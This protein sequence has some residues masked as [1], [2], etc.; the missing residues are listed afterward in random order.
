MSINMPQKSEGIALRRSGDLH[1]ACIRLVLGLL[2]CLLSQNVSAHPIQVPDSVSLTDPRFFKRPEFGARFLASQQ[3]CEADPVAGLAQYQA[4]WKESTQFADPAAQGIIGTEIAAVLLRQ[5][6]VSEAFDWINQV[7]ALD[8][9]IDPLSPI[10]QRIH[11]NIAGTYTDFEAHNLAL[12]HYKLALAIDEAR[13]QAPTPRRFRHC[14]ATAICFQQADRLDSAF[15]YYQRCINIATE[16]HE[17]IWEA[18]ARNNLGMALLHVGNLDSALKLYQTALA[19]LDPTDQT[20]QGFAVS[21]RDNIGDG[22]L[23]S[24]RAAEALPYFQVNFDDFAL[25]PNQGVHLQ[26]G[27]RL[28]HTFVAMNRLSEAEQMLATMKAFAA[29][30]A[31]SILL[32]YRLDLLETSILVAQNTHNWQVASQFQQELIQLRDS[33]QGKAFQTKV[34]TLE[35]MLIDKTTHF[36]TEIYLS[37]RVASEA[38]AKASFQILLVASAAITAILILAI[39]LINLRRRA[40]QENARHAQESYARALAEL[41][42]KNER[43]QNAQLNQALEMKRRDITDYA[44]VYSQRRNAFE[45]ILDNLKQIRRQ[46]NPEKAVQDLIMTLKGKIEGEGK[47]SLEAE[48]IEKVNHAFFDDL[49]QKFPGLSSSELELCGM[50]RLGHSSKDIALRKNIAPA[51]VRIAKTRLKKKMGLG[52]ETDLRDFLNSI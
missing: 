7:L 40:I 13:E 6:R 45:E 15:H 33:L 49:K 42:L 36:N 52:P 19:M 50:L 4:L 11:R 25:R 14:S 3:L 8:S 51:S 24:N 48:Q 27:L 9:L 38:K 1:R 37:R 28:V 30:S 39:V 31:P 12:P 35:G 16:L 32:R 21:V 18:S 22:L 34:R 5:G 46:P 47:L 2:I 44:L 20:D 17:P 41:N 29:K 10:R 26:A 43:L 23:Q